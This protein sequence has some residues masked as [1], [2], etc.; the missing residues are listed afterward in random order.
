MWR[1][2]IYCS[3]LFGWSEPCTE[4][5]LML[6]KCNLRNLLREHLTRG[7]TIFVGFYFYNLLFLFCNLPF[8]THMV[9][10]NPVTR[11]QMILQVQIQLSDMIIPC[12]QFSRY[13]I[14]VVIPLPIYCIWFYMTAKF[15]QDIIIHLTHL[16]FLLVV[17]D[18]PCDLDMHCA[19]LARFLKI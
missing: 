8:P 1:F 11:L 3:F 18:L 4:H 6:R 14:W 17:V 5:L 12:T 16:H 2:M 9:F 7:D 13:V 19:P 15:L 10:L